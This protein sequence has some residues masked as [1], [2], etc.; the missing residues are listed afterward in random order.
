MKNK[1][2][3]YIEFFGLPA[4]GK[5]TIYNALSKKLN[6]ENI[7]AISSSIE[8]I[9]L[10]KIVRH[11]YPVLFRPLLTIKLFLFC[12]KFTNNKKIR[13]YIFKYLLIDHLFFSKYNFS[14]YL[15][16]GPLHYAVSSDKEKL[17]N[18]INNYPSNRIYLVF[19]NTSPEII[20]K[21]KSNRINKKIKN[22]VMN[23]EKILKNIKNNQEV[24]NFFKNNKNK[25]NKIKDII[26]INGDKPVGEN[27][28]ILK[29]YLYE[30]N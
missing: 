19:I 18:L 21:R 2:K 12:Y 8:F 22:K 26:E 9:K 24:F 5:T 14:Y 6:K 13:N 20:C 25:N 27:V 4:S 1:E 7:K 29:K 23:K 16:N 17:V 10:K 30:K 3:I 15:N 28:E 11:I